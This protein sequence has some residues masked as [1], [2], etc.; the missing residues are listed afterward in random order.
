MMLKIIEIFLCSYCAI[1]GASR[2]VDGDLSG[3][4]EN[5]LLIA[6]I[7]LLAVGVGIGILL[8]VFRVA[9]KEFNPDLESSDLEKGK[10]GP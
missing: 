9:K 8:Y 3:I 2:G 10:I 4:F 1:G 5:F 6:G 7:L